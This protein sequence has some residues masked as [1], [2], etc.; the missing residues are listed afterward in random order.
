MGFLSDATKGITSAAS[1]V[2]DTATGVVDRVT[3]A[4][5]TAIDEVS[6]FSTA[7]LSLAKDVSSKLS[8]FSNLSA[9]MKD[10]AFKS[11][12]QKLV[13]QV[14]ADFTTALDSA[15]SAVTAIAAD[16]AKT[17]EIK[18]TF[19]DNYE[20]VTD[21]FKS[22]LVVL[23]KFSTVPAAVKALNA[24]G[25]K[26]VNI[27]AQL[28]LTGV[29]AGA[30]VGLGADSAAL[31]KAYADSKKAK[32]IDMVWYVGFSVGTEV[33]TETAVGIEMGAIRGVPTD[34]GGSQ[35][36]VSVGAS[37]EVG[38]KVELAFSTD[39]SS[40]LGFNVVPQTGVGVELSAA[41]GKAT[42]LSF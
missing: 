20:A 13:D 38:L 22:T 18:D 10:S 39:F 14:L 5:G 29:P 9:A 27:G 3:D 11:A 40:F 36:G 33:S 2:A 35:I 15:S 25:F 37:Y 24:M 8:K 4:L 19:E 42:T 17:K 41:E 7:A 32:D 23:T 28:S 6:G 30:S 1:A 12:L 26:T 16:A 21:A 31:D 34:L